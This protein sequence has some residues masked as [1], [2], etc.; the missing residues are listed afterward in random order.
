MIDPSIPMS[1]VM[2]AGLVQVENSLAKSTKRDGNRYV[3]VQ[4]CFRHF[5]LEK[6]GTD[7]IHLSLFE[8][9]GAFIFG[10]DGKSGTVKR[11]WTLATSVLGLDK[12]HIW[13][14]YFNGGKVTDEYL[15][16]DLVTRNAWLETG[17]PDDHVVG[18]GTENNYWIQG[19]GIN[20]IGNS[21]KCGPNT[22]LFYDRGIQK[23]CSNNCMPGCKCGRFIEFSNSLFINS[24]IKR[25]GKSIQPLGDPFTET[26]IG[27][28]RIAMIHQGS[29]SVF[30][31]DSIKP[32]ITIL[33]RHVRKTIPLETQVAYERVIVDH[34]RGLYFLITDGA[35]PPGKDGRARIIKMLI[36]RVATR[37]I[38]LGI[39]PEIILPEI[40]ACISH[41][42]PENVR[43]EG[44]KERVISFFLSEYERFSRT[45]KRGEIKLTQMLKEN[46]GRTLSGSQIACLEK[47][48]GMPSLLTAMILKEL[49]LSFQEDEYKTVLVAANET[50]EILAIGR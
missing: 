41:M 6:V 22:E 29:Q 3:L 19:K 28:E 21:R 2:S 37:Q 34:L 38:I 49:G 13:A 15:P 46:S 32:L 35:P 24:E 18:L 50:K 27:T 16:E 7:D 9:P 36:R 23:K 39:D 20:D 45:I 26:V 8:M 40:L 14:T 4:E 47:Q 42:A 31:I 11:M 10:P 1:F 30:E 33:R 25:N 44:T 43:K 17:I 5:D 48:W 12:E